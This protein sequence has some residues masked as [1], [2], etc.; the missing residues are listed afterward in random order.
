MAVAGVIAAYG[1]FYGN[2]ILVVGAMAVSPDLLPIAAMCIGLLALRR[3]ARRPRLLHADR[4]R[5]APRA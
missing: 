1:V 3:A 5:S 2:G 4:R